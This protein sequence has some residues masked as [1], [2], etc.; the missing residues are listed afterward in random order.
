MVVGLDRLDK[1]VE[2][3]PARRPV[4]IEIVE[5][6]SGKR[7]AD[8]LHIHGEHGEYLPPGG[9]H[10]RVNPHWFE[11]NYGEFVNGLN[12]YSYV[13]GECVA[14]LPV[15]TVFIEIRRGYEVQPL[16]QRFE[17][18]PDTDHLIFQLERVLDWRASGWVTADTH[19]HFLSPSTALL[20][21][22][23]EGVDVDG[24]VATI[25]RETADG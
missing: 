14:D 23:A 15:G 1:A 9:H 24:I 17:V 2:M 22:E 20:E 4:T 10:R 8:R 6:E 25:L 5:K 21:G 13:D 7:V 12:Q 19:V 16:R 18:A 11:D 3:P